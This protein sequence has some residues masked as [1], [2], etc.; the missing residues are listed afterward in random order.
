MHPCA[1]AWVD[2]ASASTLAQLRPGRVPQAGWGDREAPPST[3]QGCSHASV[4][5]HPPSP[6]GPIP[7]TGTPEAEWFWRERGVSWV[8]RSWNFAESSRNMARASLASSDL[9]HLVKKTNCT[10]HLVSRQPT[11]RAHF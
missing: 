7:G 8:I 5:P 1:V 3:L 6:A 10:T 9:T 11:N 4:P 2:I